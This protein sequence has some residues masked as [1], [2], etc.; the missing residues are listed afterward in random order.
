[1][2]VVLVDDEKNLL[3][4]LSDSL[5]SAGADVYTFDNALEALKEIPLIDPDIIVT[6]LKMPKVDGIEFIKKAQR[7]FPLIPIV[8]LTAYGEVKTA[9]EAV[10]AGAKDYYVKPV[11]GVNLFKMLSGLIRELKKGSENQYFEEEVGIRLGYGEFIGNSSEAVRIRHQITKASQSS[12]P[13]IIFGE[14]GVGKELIARLIHK[15]SSFSTGPF[16]R[17]S[18]SDGPRFYQELENKFKLASGGSLLLDDF[19]NLNEGSQKAL[20]QF[21]EQRQS[22]V[23]I[24]ATTLLPINEV[25]QEVVPEL[26]YRLSVLNIDVPRLQSRAN[27]IACLAAYFVKH[28]AKN[29]RSKEIQIDDDVKEVLLTYSWPGNVRELSNVIEQAM[30]MNM[31]GQLRVSD[32]PFEVIEG[33]GNNKKY[34]NLRQRL[35]DEERRLIIKA[36]ESNSYIQHRASKVLGISRSLLNQK[37]KRLKIEIKS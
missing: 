29:S 1:M 15:K 11:D 13:V 4:V 2:K 14:I 10:K 32:L 26:Y 18:C 36:L 22:C 24:L 30:V 9:V 6:D 16:I 33:S 28:F 31:G 34:V 27:D 17:V 8:V 19:S 7:I 37:I 12:A 25:R 21:I 23:R 5:I 35:L 3:L 20:S